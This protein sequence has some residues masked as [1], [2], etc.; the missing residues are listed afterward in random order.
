MKNICFFMFLLCA[1][2]FAQNKNQNNNGTTIDNPIKQT[3]LKIGDEFSVN[4]KTPHP[5][6]SIGKRGVLFEKEFYS[7]N[8]SYIKLY[9]ENFNL[10]PGDYVE[11][12]DPSTGDSIIYGE[13]G[14]VIDEN[15]TMISDFWSKVIFNEKV[16]VRLHTNG[17]LSNNYGFDIKKVAYGYSEERINKIISQNEELNKAICEGDEKEPIECYNGTEMYEKG[18]SVCRLLIGGSSLCTGWLLGCEGNLMTNNHCIGSSSEAANTDFIFNYQY[19]NCNG[20]NPANSDVV[21][22]SSSFIKT[23]STLDYTLVKLPVNPT[24]QYGYLSL[25]SVAPVVGDRIYIVG[26][27]GGRRKEI[28]V[29]TNIGGTADGYAQVNIVNTNGIRYYAD[30]EGGSSGSPVLKYNS[31]LVVAIHNT[32]GCP[33]GSYGRSDKLIESIG[34][35]MPNCGIDDSGNGG[36]EPTCSDGIQ[37]G[38]ETGI[39]CGGPVCEPCQTSCNENQ[40][41]LSITFDNYP[42]ET[43]WDLVNG[44]GLIVASGSYSTSNAD[45]STIAKT[46]CLPDDCYTFTMRDSYGDG[47]CCA[48]GNG[49][50]SLTGP[51]GVIKTGGAFSTSEATEFCLGQVA[52]VDVSLD[53]K[54]DNY[55]EE[56]S[57]EIK[58]DTGAIVTSGGTYGNQADGSLLTIEECLPIG[59]YSLTVKD[60]YGDGMCCA[61]G[62]GLYTLVNT[63]TGATLASGG[64]FSRSDTNRFCV[65]SEVTNTLLNNNLENLTE[66]TYLNT[67]PNP[68]N[69]I[70][71]IRTN[72]NKTFNYCVYNLKGQNIKKGVISNNA[73]DLSNLN[74]GAYILKIGNDD[75]QII[76]KIIKVN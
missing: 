75:K 44:T 49:S 72:I 51:E 48:Y 76:K 4:I 61:Y 14:K 35:S 21:A 34:T 43:S 45:G 74:N 56:T 10:L 60:S 7:K 23:N 55:P 64:A 65:G 25:S 54:F 20:T 12:F 30:T 42:Q 58:D 1:V 37:N 2:T 67:Y 46:L 70:L 62:D 33:N 32:G 13:R 18:K 5:Y 29:N 26:H 11:I 59:C 57:W 16:I 52:C 9:F 47:I 39:D 17:Q 73:I 40:V 15:K 50:Y 41:E 69:N 8:S 71:Y 24:A 63:A 36:G 66:A 53:L 68:I 27:P 28:T 3:P 19:Q 38:S 22:S 6:N 31:N